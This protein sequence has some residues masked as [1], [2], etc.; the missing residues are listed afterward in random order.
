MKVENSK[1]VKM[2]DKT[3]QKTFCNYFS[4]GIDGKV[5]F[6][7]DKHRTG[8][9]LG[10]MAVYGAMGAKSH[11]EKNKDMDELVE[12]LYITKDPDS[13]ENHKKGKLIFISKNVKIPVV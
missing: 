13:E 5:G 12:S 9:R 6:Q 8:T 11:L 2:T 1:E 10:N 3:L 4:F 7:F